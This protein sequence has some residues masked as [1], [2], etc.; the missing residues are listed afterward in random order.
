MYDDDDEPS[1]SL[2]G[3]ALHNGFVFFSPSN[4]GLG[5]RVLETK[6]IWFRGSFWFELKVERDMIGR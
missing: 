5:A 6:D 2:Y 4:G 3:G 1:A